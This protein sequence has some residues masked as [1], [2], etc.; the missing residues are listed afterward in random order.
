MAK[1]FHPKYIVFMRVATRGKIIRKRER[2]VL[3][4]ESAKERGRDGGS[5]TCMR[6]SPLC[7]PTVDSLCWDFRKGMWWRKALLLG[8]LAAF[9]D[10]YATCLCLPVRANSFSGIA[11]TDSCAWALLLLSLLTLSS[12]HLSD[13]PQIYLHLTPAREA[14]TAENWFR[15]RPTV[16]LGDCPSDGKLDEGLTCTHSCNPG[17]TVVSFFRCPVKDGDLDAHGTCSGNTMTSSLYF[18]AC[19][20]HV[21]SLLLSLIMAYLGML[22]V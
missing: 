17:Y 7:T 8:S 9:A 14:R 19:I 16:A 20:L 10:A 18:G 22:V 6:L 15:H 21:C 3:S 5:D 2:G 13:T 1:L 12:C 4:R 11:T